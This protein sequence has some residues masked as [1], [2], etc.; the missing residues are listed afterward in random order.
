MNLLQ[1]NWNEWLDNAKKYDTTKWVPV[2]NNN[3]LDH[4]LPI[5]SSIPLIRNENGKISS[6]KTIEALPDKILQ[7]PN[8][9]ISGEAVR[10]MLGF[11]YLIPRG[12]LVN[13]SMTKNPRLASFTPLPMYAHK[14]HNDVKYEEWDKKDPFLRFFLG[15]ALEGLRTI[16]ER[17]PLDSHE[18]RSFR[19]KALTYSSGIKKGTMAPLDAYKCNI[20]GFKFRKAEDV[21][22]DPEWDGEEY[23]SYDY[24]QC[25]I[26]MILQIWLAYAGVRKPDI[27]I[28]D[29]WRWDHVPEA[30]DSVSQAKEIIAEKTSEVPW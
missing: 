19:E 28:L 3:F 24:P 6:T 7:T 27:M 4:T 5:L 12:K 30:Y 10:A 23:Y 26:M 18:I 22:A 14:L 11:L 1:V 29:P 17:V 15:K 13:G 9:P 21:M 8:G 25:A 20:R 16:G 2:V